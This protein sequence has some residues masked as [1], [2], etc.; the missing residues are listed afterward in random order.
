M[1][2]IREYMSR[3]YSKGDYA[4]GIV[5]VCL[6]YT[7]MGAIW[8]IATKLGGKLTFTGKIKRKENGVYDIED[9]EA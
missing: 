2:K 4:N 6:L 5:I 3:P 1:N 7:I 9:E 8:L